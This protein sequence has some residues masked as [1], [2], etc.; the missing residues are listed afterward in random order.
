[1][2]VAQGA[3]LAGP[4][5]PVEVD[6]DVRVTLDDRVGALDGLRPGEELARDH[7]RS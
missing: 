7:R 1:M 3:L 5:S 4:P 2:V 6:R